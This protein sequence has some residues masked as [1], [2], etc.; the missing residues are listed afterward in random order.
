VVAIHGEEFLLPDFTNV[1]LGE[2]LH[3]CRGAF[4]VEHGDNLLR[5]LIAEE[6]P[7]NFFVILDIV[8]LNEFDE[9]PLCVTAQCRNAETRIRRNETRWLAEQVREITAP[10]PRHQ[11]LLADPVRSFEHS[12]SAP[13]FARNYCAHQA[14]RSA[15]KNDHVKC[16][17]ERNSTG[18]TGARLAMQVV[19]YRKLA[20]AG[21]KL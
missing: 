21:R 18:A 8:K 3:L 4:L 16:F 15:A 9:V 11:N 2:Y 13:S 6:L 14:G 10:A 12:H 7:G 5:G 17:H 19:D 20:N 1:G